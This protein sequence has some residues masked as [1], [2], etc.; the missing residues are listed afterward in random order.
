V[1]QN[2]VP[3]EWAIEAEPGT[4][5]RSLQVLLKPAVG[6]CGV[7]YFVLATQEKQ[8]S[9]RDWDR[10]RGLGKIRRLVR[11]RDPHTLGCHSGSA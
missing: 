3:E 11:H 5:D 1:W 4:L 9:R 7:S 8:N 10:G 2:Q 6:E